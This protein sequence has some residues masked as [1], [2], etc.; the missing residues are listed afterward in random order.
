MPYFHVFRCLVLSVF[1][2]ASSAVALADVREIPIREFFRPSEFS[3]VRISPNGRYVAARARLPA[4]PDATNIAVIDTK[5]GKTKVITGYKKA[6]VS[7]ISWLSNDRLIFTLT[8]GE[9][10]ANRD[11]V[12]AGLFTIGRDG[13]KGRSLQQQDHRSSD[14][15]NAKNGERA[16][17]ILNLLP[18]D[19]EYVLALMNTNRYL[20]PDVYKMKVKTGGMKKIQANFAS[21]TE[22]VPDNDGVLR[23]AIGDSAGLEDPTSDVYYRATEDAQWQKVG[24]MFPDDL[25]V[26]GFAADNASV[27]VSARIN[28]DRHQFY[29]MDPASFEFGEPII[30][31]P[32][33]DVSGSL[34]Y[35]GDGPVFLRY[36]TDKSNTVFFDADLNGLQ[37]AVDGALPDTDNLIVPARDNAQRVLIYAASSREP[38]RY[39]V[40]DRDTNKLSFLLA[41]RSWVDAKEMAQ[42]KPVSFKARDGE[43]IHGYLTM[44]VGH[45]GNVPMIIHPHG[46]PYG[47]RDRWQYNPEIQFLANRGYGVLQV[48]YRG[49]GGYGARFQTMAHMQWGLEMQDDLTDA[50]KWAMD[51]GLVDNDRIA[52]YGASYGGY[53]TMMGVTKTPDLFKAGINYVGV[54]DLERQVR[55]WRE[56]YNISGRR[57]YMENFVREC[58]G[59]WSNAEDVA[60]WKDTSPI[61]HIDKIEVPLLVIHGRTDNRVD[62]S[63]YE[64]LVSALKKNR[65]PFKGI[66][67]RHEGHG[68]Y[69]EDNNVELYTEI[70]NFL[71]TNL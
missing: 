66:M 5:T 16:P 37:K 27:F 39:Y 38:G 12:A 29:Q 11:A 30:S 46:G 31:D 40:F 47:I 64:M 57:A 33:Y 4:A 69:A 2:F 19:D 44:P 61:N 10:D 20:Y 52:I 7:R 26:H 58:I 60:R 63:Q 6:D 25:R 9:D 13:K 71:T 54:V 36:S 32:T 62:I 48:N 70:Q 41:A 34:F 3:G 8:K 35:H 59:D 24:N 22:W 65:K 45:E 28:S 67:K 21:I 50:A 55:F 18:K 23:L 56:D 51:E 42:M 1:V 49:S 15:T 14:M 53:A 43:T 17:E 68:F